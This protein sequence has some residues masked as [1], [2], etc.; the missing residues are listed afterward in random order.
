MGNICCSQ[1]RDGRVNLNPCPFSF[2][3]S[4]STTSRHDELFVKKLTYLCFYEVSRTTYNEVDS[5]IQMFPL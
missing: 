2:E 1:Y 4:V 3:A 5:S